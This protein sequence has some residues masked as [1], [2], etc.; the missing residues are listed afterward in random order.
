MDNSVKLAILG[1]QNIATQ[2]DDGHRLV[3]RKHN[4]EVDENRHVLSKRID[5]V[6]FCGAFELAL[7]G[8]YET[9]R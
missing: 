4:E 3:G 7:R 5:C 8:H 2:L 1:W 6:K 9:D